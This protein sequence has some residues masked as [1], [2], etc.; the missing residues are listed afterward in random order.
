MSKKN[1][2]YEYAGAFHSINKD[3]AL[4]LTD[5]SNNLELKIME[6]TKTDAVIRIQ[7]IDAP[8]ANALRRII[9]SEIETMAIDKVVMYQNTSVM[10]DEILAHRLGLVPFKINPDV[11]VKKD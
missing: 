10:Q 6:K 4:N 7:G 1:D 11:F 8:F 9:M 2:N 3:N 5:F